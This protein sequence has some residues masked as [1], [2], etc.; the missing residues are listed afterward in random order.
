MCTDC[1]VLAV[2]KSNI[3]QFKCIFC[4]YISKNHNFQLQYSNKRS[5]EGKVNGLWSYN[6]NS[7]KMT[8]VCSQRCGHSY[9]YENIST[10]D[11]E[12]D[13]ERRIDDVDDFLDP[14][15]SEI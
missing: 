5:A 14:F 10:A 2:V 3:M 9:D 15:R 13:F 6:K 8:C 12:T 4:V 7:I 11:G 1:A